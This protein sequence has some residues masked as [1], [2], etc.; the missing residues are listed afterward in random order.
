WRRSR[1]PTSSSKGPPTMNQAVQ[2]ATVRRAQQPGQSADD[3]FCG[4][5]L[6]RQQ[7]TPI[8]PGTPGGQALP[9]ASLATQRHER[10]PDDEPDCSHPPVMPGNALT[11]R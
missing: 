8:L 5:C 6:S 3:S 1:G 11:V 2:L 4:S 10:D 9:R 7:R